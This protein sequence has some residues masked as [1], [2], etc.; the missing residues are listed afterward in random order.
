MKPMEFEIS[1]AV[2][3]V[4][5][6]NVGECSLDDSVSELQKYMQLVTVTLQCTD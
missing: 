2:D 3:G 5:D 6:D 4:L 1:E